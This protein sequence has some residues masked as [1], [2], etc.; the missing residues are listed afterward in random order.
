MAPHISRASIV[1]LVTSLVLPLRF[2]EFYSSPVLIAS[3][4]IPE[5]DVD[6]LKFPLNL[7]YLEAEFF[8]FGSLGY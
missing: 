1:V 8:L 4:A 6:L 2:S 3:A 7:E 5:S